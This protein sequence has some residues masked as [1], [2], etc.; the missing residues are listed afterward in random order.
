MGLVDA[1]MRDLGIL[2]D[3]KFKLFFVERNLCQ[4]KFPRDFKQSV[5]TED[6]F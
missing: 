1:G 2:K 4:I 5:C 3:N 6:P